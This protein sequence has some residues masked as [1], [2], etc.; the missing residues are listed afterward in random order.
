MYRQGVGD[1]FLLSFNTP[2]KV[3]HI[4][5]DCGVLMGTPDGKGW[6]QRI[7][8][9]VERETRTGGKGKVDAIVG[10]HPH[11]DHLSGF[12]DAQDVFKRLTVGEVWLSWAENP[13]DKKA[14]ELKNSRSLQLDAVR[15][16]LAQL[17]AAPDA[18]TRA[19]ADAIA[20]TLSFQGPAM[21]GADGLSGTD[22]A[23]A[24][25]RNL[26][27]KPQ[28]W[29]PGGLITPEWLPG[30]RIY[31]MGPPR[32]DK[33]LS[34]ML[35]SKGSEMYGLGSDA[36]FHEALLSRTGGAA[37]ADAGTGGAADTARPF[38]EGLCWSAEQV[39]SR[40]NGC[41]RASSWRCSS[42]VSS[43]T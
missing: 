15:R 37:A 10:T 30:V 20:E 42:T 38:D 7:A 29:E 40:T 27:A 41:S 39:R 4:L 22:A 5:I 31:V 19:R 23:L 25:L 8:E 26:V 21:A 33:L 16:S 24:G 43:T 17:A 2:Q 9:D 13:Q 35:G 34:K 32:D 14:K 1:S 11:W 18:G 36:G 3:S 28:Y 12:H 6:A